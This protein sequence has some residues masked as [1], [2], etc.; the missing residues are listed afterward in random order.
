ME[1]RPYS[2]HLAA[3]YSFIINAVLSWTSVVVFA[4]LWVIII[5]RL[6][7]M[8]QPSR[9]I[10]IF[11]IV[12]FLSVNIFGGVVAVM[13]MMDTSGEELIFSGTYQCSI[14]YTEDILLLNP[15]IWI[16]VF[17]WVVLALCHTVWMAVKRFRE[18][19]QSTGRIV[20][21]CFT[22]LIKTHMLYFM[23]MVVVSCFIFILTF[24]PD[25]LSL[26]SQIDSGLCQVLLV[27]QLFVL[28]PRLILSIREYHAKLVADS[29]AATGMTTIAF[30]WRAH[31]S[32]GSS[33]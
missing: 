6:Y 21:D 18:R 4:M 3:R 24:S 2:D 31:I 11:L 32:T 29:D 27:M 5:T 7:A 17:V 19:Q 25:T 15:I 23:G 33:V 9:K 13:A 26:E 8:Y 10:L 28:G 22:M 30:E 20:Q 16:L 1:Y 14:S 12:T